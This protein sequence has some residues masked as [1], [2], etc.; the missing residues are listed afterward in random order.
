MKCGPKFSSTKRGHHKS[1][2]VDLEKVTLQIFRCLN[3]SDIAP[4]CRRPFD[5][6]VAQVTHN[7][8]FTSQCVGD[9]ILVYI[10]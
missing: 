6:F 4:D 2:M 9:F 1:L 3:T 10:H 5:E 8:Y 7:F